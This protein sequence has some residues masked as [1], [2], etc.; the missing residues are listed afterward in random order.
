MSDHITPENASSVVMLNDGVAMPRLGLGVW[1]TPPEQTEAVVSQAIALGYRSI[2]T[3]RLYRNESGVGA[4][5]AGHS[6]VFVTTK[7]WNDEQGYDSVFR[8]FDES[9]RLLQRDVIDLYLIHWPMPM[10][11]QYVES[12]KALIRLKQEGR[13]RSIG[14][15]NFM[16][17]HLERIIQETSV[18]PAVN[19]IELHPYFQQ[20]TLRSF[21][22]DYNICIESWRPLGKGVLLKDPVIDGIAKHHH[23]TPA[24]VIIRWHLQND[25]VVI[26]KTV[27]PTR[28]A[29][30]LDVFNFVL[31]D[32]DMMA[33]AALD[34]PDGRMGEDPLTVSF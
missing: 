34:R 16:E 24:Q 21:H 2:D 20:I 10:Q 15:S 25:L 7:L 23:K 14:V 32:E 3:A 33:I 19:Q 12:W 11:N 4:G 13:V 30:N 27:H 22:Q 5:V 18:V 17:E 9:A 6:D 8:A 31:T 26:P 29:E 1:Q 28:L